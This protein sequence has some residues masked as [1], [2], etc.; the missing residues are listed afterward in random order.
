MIRGNSFIAKVTL[1]LLGDPRRKECEN[2]TPGQKRPRP[3]P[4][5]DLQ[6]AN[7][8]MFLVNWG[9]VYLPRDPSSYL[10]L[11]DDVY[12]NSSIPELLCS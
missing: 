1:R 12:E 2:Q 6:V 8:G 3:D 7:C 5:V 9:C 10:L 4:L 11:C